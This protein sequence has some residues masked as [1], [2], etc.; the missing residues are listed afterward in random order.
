M[1]NWKLW[2]TGLSLAVAT[3]TAAQTFSEQPAYPGRPNYGALKFSQSTAY[4]S[5]LMRDVHRNNQVRAQELQE[6]FASKKGMERYITDAKRRLWDLIGSQPERTPLHGQ[7]VGTVIGEGFKVEKIVFESLQGR[8]VTAHLYLPEQAS[9]PLPACIEMCGHGL[10]GKGNGSE[11]AINMVA[12]G[13]AVMV[14]DPL[15]QGERLQLIDEKGTPLTRGV[16]T[17]HTLLNP[18]FNLLGSSLAAQEFW[19]NSR[20]ID[21]LLTRSDIDPNRIGA[22]GFSGGGTQ[23]SYLLALDDRVKVGCI[24][25]FFSQRARTL[26]LQG[27]SDGCQQIPYEGAERIEGADFALMMAPKP[28]IVLDGKYDYVDHWGALCSF[29]ELQKAYS[30]LGH[31]ERV[32]QYYA[33]DAHATPPDVQ[34]K[35]IEWFKLWL[36]IGKKG[37]VVKVRSGQW[38]GKNMLCTTSGQVNMEYK[39]ARSTMT[40]TRQAMDAL[41][42]ERA[43]FLQGDSQLIREKILEMLGLKQGFNDSI[44]MVPTGRSSLREYEEYRYQLNCAGEMPLPCVVWV[45]STVREDSP[46]EIH[47]HER[48]KAWYL[49]DLNKRDAV[50]N[51]RIIV[52]ADFRGLGETEDPYIYNYSKYWNKEYRVAVTSMHIGRP[53]MGQRVADMRTLLNFCSQ[54]EKL[55]GRK[56]TVVADGVYGPVVMH[57]A[58]LDERIRQ[59]VLT[60]CLKS[61]KEYLVN[62]LQR[63]MYSN[64]LFGVLP[65]YDLPDLLELS[66]R[67]VRIVD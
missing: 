21:Y 26:E 19:D 17:E 67:R 33:E 34:H 64:V 35:L 58:V 32:A 41:A 37:D 30:I 53:V 49:D 50:S 31:P 63:D 36:Q 22:Y 2:I 55:K 14:V 44:E 39:D 20:A 6:A 38:Q 52:T 66:Q 56:I 24:G 8:Y 11:L 15:A 48:G 23:A 54:D 3:A 16:T 18:A 46:I 7:V 1:K 60:R 57:A 40:E 28:F 65:Y 13:M 43:R 4:Y 10:A 61:W 25:L 62:P 51:G 45:P 5:Y 42:P 47:L 27:P 29:E 9:H 59:A 12:N